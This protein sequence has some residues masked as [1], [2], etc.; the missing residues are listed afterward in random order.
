MTLLV[1]IYLQ[2]VVTWP[3]VTRLYKATQITNGHITL[4]CSHDYFFLSNLSL[5]ALILSIVGPPST[6]WNVPI[7]YQ[8]FMGI[9]S[10]GCCEYI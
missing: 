9:A 10:G 3:N 6:W 5:E 8:L 4:F 7:P 2:Q 1:D